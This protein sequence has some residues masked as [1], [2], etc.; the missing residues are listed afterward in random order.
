M[1]SPLTLLNLAYKAVEQKARRASIL[2]S[3]LIDPQVIL[4]HHIAYPMIKNGST[5]PSAHMN[6]A[7]SVFRTRSHNPLFKAAC[8]IG[9]LLLLLGGAEIWYQV[10]VNNLK[11]VVDKVGQSIIR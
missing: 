10:R 8:I 4:I 9:A 6:N 2:W 5:Y 11:S 1:D 7:Y 3:L